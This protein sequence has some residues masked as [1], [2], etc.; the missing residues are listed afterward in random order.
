MQLSLSKKCLD[1]GKELPA[2]TEYFYKSSGKRDGLNIYCKQCYKDHRS[3]NNYKNSK[4]YHK[5][6]REKHKARRDDDYKRLWRQSKYRRLQY[7]KTQA[8]KRGIKFG[9]VQE[10]IDNLWGKPCHYCGMQRED[11]IGLDRLDS[12][13]PY[14]SDN[15][16]P[17]CQECNTKKGSLPYEEYMN[18]TK[19]NK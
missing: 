7:F 18:K 3:K 1:C 17:C 10:D 15:V 11:L 8:N 9:L 12:S 4:S 6:Y 14:H 16:V 5:E 13:G 19:K 2:T